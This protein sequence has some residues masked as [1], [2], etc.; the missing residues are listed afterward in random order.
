MCAEPTQMALQIAHQHII[1]FSLI[2]RE[3]VS[4]GYELTKPTKTFHEDTF[5]RRL[6]L[7]WQ[8]LMYGRKNS[9]KGQKTQKNAKN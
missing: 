8:L 6:T 9:K 7:N 3:E 5:C 4:G 2:N 1:I